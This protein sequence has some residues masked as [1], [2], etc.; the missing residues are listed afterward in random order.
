MLMIESTASVKWTVGKL[1]DER[2]ITTAEFARMAQIQYQTALM[3]R[4]GATTQVD[5]RVL[6]RICA[7]LGVQ[8]G[9]VLAYTE[10]HAN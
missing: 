10:E 7:A 8:P 4:R 6:G 1:L 3:I 9:D 2:K 5:T